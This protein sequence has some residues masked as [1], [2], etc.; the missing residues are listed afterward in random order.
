MLDLVAEQLR[1]RPQD[2]AALVKR[3]GRYTEVSWAQLWADAERVG[4][5]LVAVGIAPGDRVSIV[6]NTRYEWVTLDLGILAAGAVTVPI[7]PS[8]LADECL[9]V[10]DHSGARLVF[11]EDRSQV[12]KLVAVRDRLPQVVVIVQMTG[13]LE[14]ADDRVMSMAELLARGVEVEGPT[15]AERRAGLGPES[16]LTIIYTSGT[17]GRPKGVVLTHANM[18]YEAQAVRE[19]GLLEQADIQLLFLPLAHSFARVL[20]AGWLATGHVLAFAESM[21]TIKSNLAEVRPTVM[22]GVPRVFEKFHAAV[23]DKGMSAGGL[24]ARLFEAALALSSKRGKLELDGRQLERLDTIKFRL[25]SKLVFGKI[26]AAVMETLGGRMRLMVSGGAPLPLEVGWLFRDIRI[27]VLEGYGLTE[28]SAATTVNRPAD[29]QI[30]TVGPPL[31]G[32]EARIAADGEILFRGPGIMREYWRDPEATAESLIDGWF[33]TGDIGEIDQ[34]TGAIRITDRKKDLIVTAGGKNVAPQRIEN[35]VRSDGLISQCVV[36]GDRRKYLSALVTLD[37]AALRELAAQRGL[38][39]D[40][41]ALARHPEVRAAVQRIIDRANQ[42][43]AS[44]ETIKKFEILDHD[45]SI[46]T[47]ELTPKLSVKRK[48]VNSKYGHTFD[49]FYRD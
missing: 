7:Y 16:M 9:Y 24:K 22:A 18:L 2:T 13:E 1:A 29:N 34:Q 20:A 47:G 31:P 48:V 28:T 6:S 26:H 4:Q 27:L 25:L 17:T 10:C 35:L 3:E 38:T 36:H 37:E 12:E 11:C 33:H 40:Y 49:G 14:G 45:F 42:D 30:G 5:A 46:E 23:V 15:L 43:L 8:N 21:S 39:G 19:I 32:T 44:Y 41:S